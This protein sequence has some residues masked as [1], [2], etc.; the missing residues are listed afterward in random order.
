MA[1]DEVRLLDNKQALLF[2]RGER[3][4]QDR[5]FNLLQHKR[6]DATEDGG[7]AS[8]RRE[9]PMMQFSKQDLDHIPNTKISWD[10]MNE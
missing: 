5:K 7:A 1:P 8:Y 9:E 2:I 3:P 6:I 10:M 4:I